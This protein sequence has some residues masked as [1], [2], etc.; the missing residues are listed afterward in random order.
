VNG[1]RQLDCRNGSINL[2]AGVIT[3][4]PDD[5]RYEWSFQ[6]Q[7]LGTAELQTINEPGRY[8]VKA[9]ID[10]GLVQC[11][12]T[13]FVDITLNR[14]KPVCTFQSPL[15]NCRRKSGNITYTANSALQNEIW[16]TPIGQNVSGNNFPVDS[17]FAS[18]G[19]SCRFQAERADN[20]C[21]IDTLIGV[22][23]DFV[24]PKVTIEGDDLLTCIIN[25]IPLQV[26]S[27]LQHDSIRWILDGNY[28]TSTKVSYDATEVGNY[29]CW[30]KAKRNGC[31]N[32]GH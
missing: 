23:S 18:S 24:H 7:P 22:Q 31:T 3:D 11:E 13:D 21:R 15:L 9:Y 17:L 2:E 8:F 29:L 26:I 27:D 16:S 30:V 1:V 5:V 14:E 20:G 28:L 19:L 4:L 12:S 6:G 32:E 25:K 10:N